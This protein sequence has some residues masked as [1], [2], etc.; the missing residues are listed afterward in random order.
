[1]IYIL[2][3]LALC[4][5]AMAVHD[6]Y[7]DLNSRELSI[8]EYFLLGYGASKLIVIF[9]M[10]AMCYLLIARPTFLITPQPYPMDTPNSGGGIT[11]YPVE[12]IGLLQQID[13]NTKHTNTLLQ[14]EQESK[15]W[16]WISILFLVSLAGLMA[17]IY[18]KTK[19]RA[20]ISIAIISTLLTVTLTV[21]VIN[22]EKVFPKVSFFEKIYFN[23]NSGIPDGSTKPVALNSIELTLELITKIGP[24]V[25]G[26]AYLKN[27]DTQ[28]KMALDIVNQKAVKVEHFILVGVVDKRPLKPSA[29]N[30]LA[31]DKG[32]AYSRAFKV[33]Q[34]LR[35]F[36]KQAVYQRHKQAEISILPYGPN[37]IGPLANKAQLAS[38][39][40]VDVYISYNKQL[41]E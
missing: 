12:I 15:L 33:E 3:I 4:F 20:V 19:S 28:V 16:I 22:I 2:S 37:Y 41:G 13:Q 26:R 1:M 24:F 21:K 40:R 8:R 39:R 35:T 27:I 32:L 18:M 9:L 25:E 29:K 6:M 10:L 36:F 23:Y 5:T 7:L 30:V 34:S 38:D 31:T 14:V 17:W 11:T